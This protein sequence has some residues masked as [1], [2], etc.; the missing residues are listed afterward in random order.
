MID[1][2]VNNW[3]RIAFIIIAV[4]MSFEALVLVSGI[5]RF[6]MLSVAAALIIASVKVKGE[7]LL[8]GDDE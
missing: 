5:A 2:I 3:A 6:I 1:K 7:E 8:G 4:V